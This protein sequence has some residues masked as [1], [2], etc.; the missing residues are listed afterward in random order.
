M[1]VG[2]RSTERSFRTLSI[3][4]KTRKDITERVSTY[5]MNERPSLL[6]N[7][8]PTITRIAECRM[9]QTL[10]SPTILGAQ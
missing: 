9:M 5:M 10:F 8:T 6:S 7:R 4:F 3:V 1:R 2:A